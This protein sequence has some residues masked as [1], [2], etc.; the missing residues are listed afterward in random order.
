MPD[1]AIPAEAEKLLAVAPEDFV[2]ARKEL[3]TQLR[4]DGRGGE[5]QAVSRMRRR[6]LAT[7]F[8]TRSKT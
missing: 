3:A 2:D 1:E 8:Q 7:R 6:T 4:E 5:A